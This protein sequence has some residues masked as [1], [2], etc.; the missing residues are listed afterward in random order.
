MKFPDGYHWH[1]FDEN[2]QGFFYENEPESG[3]G[4][5]FGNCGAILYSEWVMPPHMDWRDS[6]TCR[7]DLSTPVH[8]LLPGGQ[9]AEVDPNGIDAHQ[10]GAKLD[11]G[12]NRVGLVVGGFAQALTEVAKV[13]TYGAHKYT[14]DGWKS[15]LNGQA[16]YTDALFRHL[17]A[18]LN[19][20]ECDSD[21]HIY[22]A[23]HAAW[24]ALARLHFLL[25]S[26]K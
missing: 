4:Q 19:G 21:T 3:A 11:A 10:L 14:E 25:E 6:L 18:E 22:H 13:G 15:V 12:K 26:K 16:R 17:F 20:E 7:T 1:A 8:H 23:A 2:G 24:N 9:K 5:W